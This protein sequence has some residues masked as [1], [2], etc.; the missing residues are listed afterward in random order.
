MAMIARRFFSK[1]A[2][3]GWVLLIVSQ[4]ERLYRLVD[5]WSNLEFII[6]KIR[7]V[8]LLAFVANVFTSVWFQISLIV[9]GLAWIAWA[10]VKTGHH[11]Y[12]RSSWP[13]RR[14]WSIEIEEDVV[15]LVQRSSADQLADR[16]RERKGEKFSLVQDDRGLREYSRQ[17]VDRLTPTQ[18]ERLFAADPAME[19][20]W[21]GKPPTSG[22]WPL[23]RAKG[24]IWIAK[25]Q[26][27]QTPKEHHGD[28][29]RGIPGLLDWYLKG[30]EF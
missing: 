6:E 2:L 14:K 30:R 7:D 18:R 4:S 28:I 12:L 13:F 24:G 1:D 11:R 25:H 17:E 20:W 10:S 26:V 9:M 23:F 5:A 19:E 8:R 21:R 15:Y 29:F 16:H 22:A 3:P 27:D